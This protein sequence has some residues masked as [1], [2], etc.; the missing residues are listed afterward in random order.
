MCLFEKAFEQVNLLVA[1]PFFSQPTIFACHFYHNYY[2]YKFSNL[3]SV[4]GQPKQVMNVKRKFQ[5]L[6]DEINQVS[7]DLRPP[8]VALTIDESL[9]KN[10][11]RGDQGGSTI[12]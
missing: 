10:H 7:D 12:L 11:A 1:S 6:I 3:L 8:E 2:L 5:D 4:N 9:R